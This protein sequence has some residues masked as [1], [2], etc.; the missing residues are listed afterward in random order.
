M[1]SGVKVLNNYET[2]DPK[3]AKVNYSSIRTFKAAQESSLENS[4]S[5]IPSWSRKKRM[6]REA[7][8]DGATVDN[9]TEIND[10][11][12]EELSQLLGAV[13]GQVLKV[14]EEKERDLWEFRNRTEQN[15]EI[16]RQEKE[17]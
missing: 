15:P 10:K 6:K 11:L 16:R 8:P 17:L 9:L 2:T 12:R 1:K 14:R 4:L 3:I 13:E 5:S 7:L